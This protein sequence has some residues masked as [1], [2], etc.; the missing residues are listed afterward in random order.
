MDEREFAS[1]LQQIRVFIERAKPVQYARAKAKGERRMRLKIMRAVILMQIRASV[2]E[3]FTQAKKKLESYVEAIS[4][5][6]SR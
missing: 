4:K 5:N 1:L 3:F 2:V 6:R